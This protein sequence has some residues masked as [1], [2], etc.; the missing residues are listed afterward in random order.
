MYEMCLLLYS[1][2]TSPGIKQ[3][4]Y[5]DST[6]TPTHTF[7][8]PFISEGWF[9]HDLTHTQSKYGKSSP[10]HTHIGQV[11]FESTDIHTTSYIHMHCLHRKAY[12]CAACFFL[13][14]T[15]DFK[16]AKSCALLYV[17]FFTS[18]IHFK[19]MRCKQHCSHSGQCALCVLA[20]G[21]KKTSSSL[22]TFN[23]AE[24]S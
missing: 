9:Q 2:P 12:M 20:E 17:S 16:A 7:T 8:H 11:L 6:Q 10:P 18:S 3:P 19:L 14:K 23:V 5:G 4:S 21:F 1:G 15:T 24:H 22:R 13:Y